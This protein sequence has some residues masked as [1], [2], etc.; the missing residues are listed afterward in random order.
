MSQRPLARVTGEWGYHRDV[1]RKEVYLEDRGRNI[2]LQGLSNTPEVEAKH[3]F[4]HQFNENLLR[5]A[6]YKTL[7][8]MLRV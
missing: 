8:K 6:L 5:A 3:K 2:R 7:N 4:L 1:K